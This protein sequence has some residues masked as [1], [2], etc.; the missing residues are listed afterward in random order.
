MPR[1]ADVH[2]SAAPCGPS[3]IAIANPRHLGL[4]GVRA[5]AVVVALAC[6]FPALTTTTAFGLASDG[7]IFNYGDAAFFGSTASL[8]LNKPTVGMAASPDGKGYW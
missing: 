1:V 2:D 5:L 3:A 7:G 6:I 4:R 8:A